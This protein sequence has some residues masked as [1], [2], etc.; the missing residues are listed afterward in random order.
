M[1]LIA[2]MSTSSQK[3]ITFTLLNL[4][5]VAKFPA[6]AERNLPNYRMPVSVGH[7]VK[8]INTFLNLKHLRRT[9]YNIH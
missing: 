7:K 1:K 3:I 4:V 6:V 8:N 2:I 9:M 5:L